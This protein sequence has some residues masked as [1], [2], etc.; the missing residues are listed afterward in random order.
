MIIPPSSGSAEPEFNKINLSSTN[1]LA[2]FTVVVVPLTV[3]LPSTTKSL[4]FTL[5]LVPKSWLIASRLALLECV[6]ET[7]SKVSILP[8]KASVTTNTEPDKAEVAEAASEATTP[9]AILAE[10]DKA[11]V[12]EAASEATTPRAV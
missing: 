8:S 4:K 3:K 5:S 10:L 9:R 7:P 1:R 2:V 12:A 11:E 6:C